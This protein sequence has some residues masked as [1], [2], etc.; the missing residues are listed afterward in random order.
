MKRIVKP[1]LAAFACSAAFLLALSLANNQRVVLE[2]KADSTG[3]VLLSDVDASA[4][5]TTVKS[6]DSK[7]LDIT[8]SEVAKQSYTTV[9]VHFGSGYES[10]RKLG[11]TIENKGENEVGF[12]TD[13]YADATHGEYEIHAVNKIATKG[14]FLLNTDYD[15]GGSVCTILPGETALIEVSYTDVATA[16]QLFIDSAIGGDLVD[17]HAGHVVFSDLYFCDGAIDFAVANMDAEYSV[18]KYS[19]S[20]ITVS[21]ESIG[22]QSYKNVGFGG[23]SDYSAARRVSFDIKNNTDRYSKVRI[24]ANTAETHGANNIYAGNVSAVKNGSEIYTDTTWG[25]SFIELNAGEEASVA[26]FYDEPVTALLVYVDSSREAGTF[27]NGSITF[28]NINF[29]YDRYSFAR[30]LLK[31]TKGLCNSSYDGVTNNGTALGT[32]WGNLNTSSYY[33]ALSDAEQTALASAAGDSAV[34]VPTTLEGIE[35]MSD[36]DAVKAA[37]Y[38]YDYCTAKYHLEN[39]IV[40]RTVRPLLL[41]AGQLVSQDNTGVILTITFV[42]VAI[43]AA[44]FIVFGLKKRHN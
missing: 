44:S 4:V 35:N 6:P 13:I 42:A 8:Y 15:W 16:V 34:V 33:G 38:R 32:I 29:G 20:G 10:Y 41:R 22:G 14:C 17:T 43:V 1:T 7:S 39:F 19:D 2:T 21:Y 3:P 28:N 12:R 24:D 40:G 37:L 23:L 25:G 18:T 30:D 9:N 36:E 27:D 5:Y 26:I 31:L 11:F